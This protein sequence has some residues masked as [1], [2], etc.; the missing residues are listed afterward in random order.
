[1]APAERA[2]G[3]ALPHVSG[4]SDRVS[5]ETFRRFL[6]WLAPDSERAGQRYI[7]LHGALVRIFTCRGC[8]QPNELADETLDRVIRKGATLIEGYE[9]NPA[10]YIH[11][12]AKRVFLEY[13]R[14]RRTRPE[15]APG[16]L[17]GGQDTEVEHKH[18]CLNRCL[19]RLSEEERTLILQYY[20]GERCAKIELRQHLAREAQSSQSALRK[21]TQR[22]REQLKS[23]V[24]ECLAEG[25]AERDPHGQL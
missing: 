15:L 4:G 16:A 9:G 23:C 3:A 7:E 12:V 14:A 21:R 2:L 8:E 20:H 13:S 1:M 17:S 5:D 19:A 22:I 25:C 18:A 11:G 6:G 24:L 10:A